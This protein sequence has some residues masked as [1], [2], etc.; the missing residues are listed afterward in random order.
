MPRASALFLTQIMAR[1]E[2]TSAGFSKNLI[3]RYVA[4]HTL[5]DTVCFESRNEFFYGREIALL[6]PVVVTF[7][8]Q[9]FVVKQR[10][11]RLMG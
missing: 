1:A 5:Y 9:I 10:P 7:S 6:K 11:A 2:T 3:C 4:A 8:P